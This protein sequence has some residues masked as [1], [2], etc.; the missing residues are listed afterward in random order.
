MS[1]QAELHRALL[2]KQ[3]ESLKASA[4]VQHEWAAA[5][6]QAAEEARRAGDHRSADEFE[7]EAAKSQACARKLEHTV[8]DTH[9]WLSKPI[10][11]RPS[12]RDLPRRGHVE[13]RRRP[14][15]RR[16]VSRGTSRGG[17]SGDPDLGDE[18][19]GHRPPSHEGAVA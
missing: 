3:A 16:C 5:D 19:P 15:L 13:G 11:R 17:D 8:R 12:P 18:P 7:Q 1:R 6:R 2:A 9:K 4:K 14:G 10:P